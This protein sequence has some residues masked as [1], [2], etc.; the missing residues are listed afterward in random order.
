MSVSHPRAIFYHTVVPGG[1]RESFYAR[2]HPTAEQFA[3]HLD[4]LQQRFTLVSAAEFLGILDGHPMRAHPRPPCL[5]SFDDGLRGMLTNAL[6][7]LEARRIPCVVFII[8]GT[9]ADSTVPWFIAADFLVCSAEGRVVEFPARGTSRRFWNLREVSGYWG[10]KAAFKELFLAA[11]GEDDRNA[12]LEELAQAVGRSV[13][14]LGELP[15][16]MRLL[17]ADEVKQ[18]SRHELITIGSHALTHRSL[19]T[20]SEGEQERELAFSQEILSGLTGTKVAMVAYPDG[21]HNEAT[22]R[23]A[24]RHYQFG[25]AV[26]LRASVRDRFAYPRACLGRMSVAGLR[27]WL[28][29]RRRYLFGPIKRLLGR[30]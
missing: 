20:L 30:A 26:E 28:S 16:E 18:L 5:L 19:A 24:Q 7:A 9:I 10:L 17:T 12:L 6:P 14:T 2:K 13:P 1:G 23:L 27:Y 4:Y 21:S 3:A 11:R 15:D 8:A 25:F 29:F 22:R